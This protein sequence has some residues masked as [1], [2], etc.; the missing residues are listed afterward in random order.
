[1]ETRVVLVEDHA[2]VREA[3]RQLVERSGNFLVVGEASD[4]CEAV[5]V[6]DRLRPDLVLMDLW[7][8]RTSGIEAMREIRKRAPGVKVIVL[9]MHEGRT[10]VQDAL[11]AGASGY[12]VKSAVCS[13]LFDAMTAVRDGRCY[14]SP[15]V[16]EHAVGAIARPTEVRAEGISALTAR[17][18]EILQRIAEGQ[19]SKEI[20]RELHLSQRTVEC[21]RTHLMRKLGAHKLST[22]VRIAIREGLLAP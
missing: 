1:M 19:A 18:R 2:L 6:V 14:L 10:F 16:T 11:R 4:G 15:A 7:L 21:H 22:L 20:A 5:E 12:V 13:E 17:E 9:S 8:P 3:V